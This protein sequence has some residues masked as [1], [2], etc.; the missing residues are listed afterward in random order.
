M[1]RN[2][3]IS[4]LLCTYLS[5]ESF[6]EFLQKAI[7]NSPY[8]ES[9]ALSV[10]QTK[11]EGEI[12]TRYKNP[13][14]ELEYS[15]LN[16]DLGSSDDSYRVNL[17][18]PI[19][20]WGVGDDKR[21][22]VNSSINTANA[23]YSQKRAIF[24]RDISLLYTNYSKM[25][26]LLKLGD[27]E[28]NIAKKIYDI[29]I[30]EFEEGRISKGLKLHSLVEYEIAN[31]S[32]EALSLDELESYFSL[33]KFAG[34]NEE[35][36]I[37][38]NYLFSVNGDIQN[39]KNPSV[40]LLEN[41]QNQALSKVKLNSNSLEWINLFAELENEPDQDIYRVGL[42]FPLAIFNNKSQ[43]KTIAMLKASSSELLIQ[44]ETNRLN[45]DFLRLKRERASLTKLYESNE[46]ILN[47]QLELLKMHEDSYKI[48]HTNLLQLQEVNNKVIKTKKSL[49]QIQTALDKNA[50]YTNY[51]KGNFNE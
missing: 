28:L 24:I 36:E 48:S 18:Q 13:T 1:F 27:E 5:A 51:S 14:L 22:V 2:I 50:I 17:S 49:I 45:M 9:L 46:N 34:I 11:E 35:I 4:L 31:N 38:E 23:S 30:A 25:K 41:Q 40:V 33:L 16:P 19:R 44:N 7:K 3:I 26:M 20:L 39:I 29:S 43:E 47:I 21:D 32:K 8:L 6:D 42:E 12:L 37:E 10:K 15:S